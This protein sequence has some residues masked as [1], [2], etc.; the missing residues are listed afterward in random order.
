[1]RQIVYIIKHLNADRWE[2][3][4]IPKKEAAQPFCQKSERQSS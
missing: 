1:M 4:T 3:L 2:T